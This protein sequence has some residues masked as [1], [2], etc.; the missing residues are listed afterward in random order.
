MYT[1]NKVERLIFFNFQG[2]G[3]KSVGGRGDPVS[4]PIITTTNLYDLDLI[5]VTQ[6][7]EFLNNILTIF[8]TFN[9]Q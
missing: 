6:V 8:F 4:I 3:G 2:G 7:F 5:R 1:L 9:F